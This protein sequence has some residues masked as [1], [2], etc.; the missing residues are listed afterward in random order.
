MAAEAVTKAFPA[1]NRLSADWT[2][3]ILH[4]VKHERYGNRAGS[5]THRKS[6][7]TVDETR[8]QIP[9]ADGGWYP[10]EKSCD[11]D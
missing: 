8:E 5:Q 2:R 9:D 4:T 6:V 7:D 3:P 11:T 1:K 10:E